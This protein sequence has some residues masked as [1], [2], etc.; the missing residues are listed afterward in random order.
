MGLMSKGQAQFAKYEG[1]LS[2]VKLLKSLNH[3]ELARIADAMGS[4][5]FDA[6]EDIITQGDEGDTF[7]ILEDGQASAFIDGDEGEIE[8]KT[9]TEGDYF[10]ELALL[11]SAPRRATVRATGEGCVVATISREDFVSLLGPI[12]EMLKTCIDN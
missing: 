11:T 7:F 12:A 1:W 4:D 9:Y 10:G 5:C 6:G 2:Q 8:V 3:F